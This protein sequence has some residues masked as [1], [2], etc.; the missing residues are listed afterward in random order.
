MDKTETKQQKP[1][2]HKIYVVHPQCRGYLHR[3]TVIFNLLQTHSSDLRTQ[4]QISSAILSCALSCSTFLPTPFAHS[5]AEV[6]HALNW[7]LTL[8][9]PSVHSAAKV[10][11]ALSWDL[12]LNPKQDLASSHQIIII[13]KPSKKLFLLYISAYLY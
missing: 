10:I 3:T 6:I 9:K 1:R 7:D 8:T 4:L 13:Q 2:R 12:T 11:R 5:A